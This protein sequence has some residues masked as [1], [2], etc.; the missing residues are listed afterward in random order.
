MQLLGSSNTC[1]YIALTIN[2]C[3]LQLGV[4]CTVC[5]AVNIYVHSTAL[6]VTALPVTTLPVT[7]LSLTALSVSAACTLTCTT[8]KT[9]YKPTTIHCHILA[10]CAV[11]SH[12][13]T[14][15]TDEPSFAARYFCCSSVYLISDSRYCHRNVHNSSAHPNK[16]FKLSVL[17]VLTVQC[18]G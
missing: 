10:V 4:Y 18:Y 7:A 16:Q 3:N 13:P 9:F 12:L 5:L 2:Q 6:Q 1:I 17:Q 15:C 8:C 11:P 14:V